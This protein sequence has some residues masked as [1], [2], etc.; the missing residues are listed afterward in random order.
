LSITGW[1]WLLVKFDRLLAVAFALEYVYSD[2]IIS[3]DF[4]GIWHGSAVAALNEAI[5]KTRSF[6]G[7]FGCDPFNDGRICRRFDVFG[8][9]IWC[10]FTK[11]DW[12]NQS[13]M[14][15]IWLN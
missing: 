2:Q 7:V 1:A 3:G 9:L 15:H 12:A 8:W 13:C 11:F 6:L 14:T 5:D 4:N 10:A